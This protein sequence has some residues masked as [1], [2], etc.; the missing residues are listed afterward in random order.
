MEKRPEH[1]GSGVSW[2]VA[3]RPGLRRRL[4]AGSAEAREE[5]EKA[6]LRAKAEHPYLYV[7][8]RFGHAKVRYRGLTKNHERLALLL[9]FANLLR[10]SPHLV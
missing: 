10:A 3:L 1:T 8:R 7:R 6:S 9:G 4:A 2:R 5:R